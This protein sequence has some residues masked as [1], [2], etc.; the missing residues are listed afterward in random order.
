MNDL[1]GYLTENCCS[2][3]SDCSTHC[4]PS[5]SITFYSRPFGTEPVVRKI[6]YAKW[7]LQDPCID[8]AS[9]PAPCRLELIT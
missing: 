2:L 9:P 8:F 6:D 3:G 1:V 7:M 4:A 5:P